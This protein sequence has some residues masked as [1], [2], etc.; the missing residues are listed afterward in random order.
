M[1]TLNTIDKLEVVHTCGHIQEVSHSF[2]KRLEA[3][4]PGAMVRNLEHLS[5]HLCPPCYCEM[6]GVEPNTYV[7][8]AGRVCNK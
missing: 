1:R 2:Y 4:F 5:S 6:Q 7:N 8:D 3:K